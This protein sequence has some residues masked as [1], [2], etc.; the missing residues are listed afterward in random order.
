MG[1]ANSILEAV[2][3]EAA[4]HPGSRATKVGVRIG[5]MAAIDEEALRFCLEVLAQDTMLVGLQLAIEFC[6][7]RHRCRDCG[8]EFVIRGY[9]FACPSCKGGASECIGGDE[10]ELAY[11]EVEEDESSPVGT[12]SSE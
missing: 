11:V 10:L 8:T 3:K 7:R 6:P 1:I 12:K 2:G 9:D 5:E 4:R